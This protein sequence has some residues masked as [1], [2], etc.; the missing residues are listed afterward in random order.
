MGV[1]INMPK[2]ESVDVQQSILGQNGRNE[3]SA[4][5]TAMRRL[6]SRCR[7]R[8]LGPGN[9]DA[10]IDESLQESKQFERRRTLAVGLWV[11]LERAAIAH[12]CA[13][14]KGLDLRV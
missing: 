12:R 11:R 8:A 14:T 9:G 5:A 1:E 10:Q 6:T 2:V 7:N 4:R 3:R 13:L